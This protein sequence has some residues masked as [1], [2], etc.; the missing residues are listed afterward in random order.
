MDR[1][2]QLLIPYRAGVDQPVR[3][4]QLQYLIK[5]LKKFLKESDINFKFIII[6]QNNDLPFNKGRLL[7]A[8]FLECEKESKDR[9]KAVYYAIQNVDLFP[10]SHNVDYSYI[11]DNHFRDYTGYNPGIGGICIFNK[12][13]FELINGCPNNFWGYGGEDI[14]MK[15][16]IDIK[17]IKL[18]H[19]DT[20][21]IIEYDNGPRK[22]LEE[23]NSANLKRIN[24]YEMDNNGLTTCV[25]NIVS[26]NNGYYDDII[27]ELI[28]H[29]KIDFEYPQQISN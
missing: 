19:F 22:F 18:D 11:E 7:N 20:S 14:D 24:P 8:G 9:N 10:K 3:K 5:Y 17:Q 23:Y 1:E 13:T 6:E 4:R 29:Y 27:D 28:V 16:R 25:Y 26:I 12:N 2:L 21:D 15:Q